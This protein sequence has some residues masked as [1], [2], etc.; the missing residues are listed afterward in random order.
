MGR[1]V[2]IEI[3]AFSLVGPT[4]QR[5]VIFPNVMITSTLALMDEKMDPE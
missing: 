2:P 4:G 5:E 3:S 1:E